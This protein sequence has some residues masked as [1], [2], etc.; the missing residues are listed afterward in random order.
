MDP[1]STPSMVLLTSVAWARVLSVPACHCR[2][3]LYT[4]LAI[5]LSYSSFFFAFVCCLFVLSFLFFSCVCHSPNLEFGFVFSFLFIWTGA[6]LF[7]ENNRQIV[8]QRFFSPL[9]VG[10]DET[11]R[12]WRL[13][14][15]LTPISARSVG[16]SRW[17]YR[18]TWG[19]SSL[20]FCLD[21]FTHARTP[22]GRK[23]LKSNCL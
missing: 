23:K 19:P 20:I 9:L 6:T 4:S 10:S 8:R 13:S 2:P 7:R 16:W 5:R 11:M 12:T 3:R 17:L 1:F 22:W 21:E 14:V 18:F 15:A